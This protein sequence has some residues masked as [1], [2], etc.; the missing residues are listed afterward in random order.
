MFVDDKSL[1]H[2]EKRWDT[3]APELMNIGTGD[4]SLWDK[5]IWTTGGLLEWLKMEYSLLIWNFEANGKPVI[6]QD[7][8]LPQN[9]V[10]IHRHGFDTAVKCISTT[11]APK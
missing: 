7:Y 2:T 9:T 11:K 10:V 3:S 8:E 1:L 5:Y 6:A 4:L